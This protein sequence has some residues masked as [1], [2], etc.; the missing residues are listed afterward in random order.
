MLPLV[1][2]DGAAQPQRTPDTVRARI[3][4]TIADEEAALL[5]EELLDLIAAT[6]Q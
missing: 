3:V 6:Q 4:K 1:T 2:V 5:D